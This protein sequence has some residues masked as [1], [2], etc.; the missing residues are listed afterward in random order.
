MIGNGITINRKLYNK[1]MVAAMDL[2]SLISF[3]QVTS[4]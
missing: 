4:T 3:L 1:L 2:Q